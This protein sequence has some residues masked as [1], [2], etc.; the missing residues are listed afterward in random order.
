[1]SIVNHVSDIES[2]AEM[3]NRLCLHIALSGSPYYADVEEMKA[4]YMQPW[5]HLKA[6]LKS[7]Y[8]SNLWTGTATFATAFLLSLIVIQ[9]YYATPVKLQ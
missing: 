6:T 7:I 9:T 8:F 5:N 2:I 1:M 3:F 4:H